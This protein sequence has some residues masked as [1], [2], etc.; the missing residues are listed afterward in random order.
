MRIAVLTTDYPTEADPQAGQFAVRNVNALALSED[1]TVLHLVA[2]SHGDEAHSV[3]IDGVSVHRFPAILTNWEGVARCARSVATLLTGY[4]LV[5]T[6][7]VRALLPLARQAGSI[8]PPVPCPWVHSEQWTAQSPPNWPSGGMSAQSMFIRPAVVCPVSENL[9]EQIRAYRNPHPT[10]V[11]PCVVPQLVN[12]PPRKVW[13]GQ[14]IRLVNVGGLVNRKLP[15]I[16]LRTVK[17]LVEQGFD[18]SYYWIGEGQLRVRMESQIKELGLQDRVHLLGSLDSAHISGQLAEA[19]LFFSP[20]RGENF[21]VPAADAILHG[22]PVV[23]GA[24]GGHVDY[25]DTRVSALVGEETSQAYADAIIRILEQAR[26]WS[27]KLIAETI[28]AKFSYEEICR[29]YVRV[30]EQAFAVDGTWAR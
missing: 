2:P 5:H 19:D 24:N 30:Y 10:V 21:F 26:S 4:D 8:L 14:S 7:S 20:T 15:H 25:L 13:N 23:T 1:V 11:V 12:V 9:A 6:M 16:A 29:Q 27:A 18:V 28:G 3:V 22:R 17:R